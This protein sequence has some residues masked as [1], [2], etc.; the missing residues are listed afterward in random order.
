M[1]SIGCIK[2]LNISNLFSIDFRVIYNKLIVHFH[3]FPSGNV[4]DERINPAADR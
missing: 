3:S 2:Y 4:D 1:V